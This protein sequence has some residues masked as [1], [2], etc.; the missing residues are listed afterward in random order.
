[1][2]AGQL[3]REDV[4]GSA[5]GRADAAVII[6]ELAYGDVST[7]AYL[8]IHNMVSH[9]IDRYPTLAFPASKSLS[10]DFLHLYRLAVA[11]L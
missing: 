8:T 1:M 6:E 5:L 4:G 10:N 3:C 7:A 9:C 2:S 11:R